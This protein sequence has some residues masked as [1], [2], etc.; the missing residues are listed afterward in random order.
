MEQSHIH[1]KEYFYSRLTMLI[2][3]VERVE[4]ICSNISET[5]LYGDSE[6]PSAIVGQKIWLPG[7]S[8]ERQTVLLQ[9]AV[10]TETIS[11]ST[12][13]AVPTEFSWKC[14]GAFISLDKAYA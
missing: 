10:S 3:D 5:T 1:R 13:T 11:G 6:L 12:Y 7:S 4:D 9:L 8:A 2:F 14:W